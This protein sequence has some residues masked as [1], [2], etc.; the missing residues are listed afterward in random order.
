MSRRFIYPPCP[1]CGAEVP[2]ALDVDGRYEPASDLEAPQY[3]EIEAYCAPQCLGEPPCRL[4][5]AEQWGVEREAYEA[6]DERLYAQYQ[7]DEHERFRQAR[8][9][10]AW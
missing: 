8:K 1:R 10:K 7:E 6:E 4:T 9:L 3:P 5:L 2:V